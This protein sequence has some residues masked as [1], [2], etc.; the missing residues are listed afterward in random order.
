[1][2]LVWCQDA[3]EQLEYD[4]DQRKNGTGACVIRVVIVT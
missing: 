3:I 1:M 4:R 2:Y